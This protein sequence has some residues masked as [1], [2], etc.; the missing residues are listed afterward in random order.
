M[1]DQHNGISIRTMNLDDYKTVGPLLHGDFVND[2]PI[3]KSLKINV[4]PETIAIIDALHL[5]MIEEGTSLVAVEENHPERILGFVLAGAKTRKD[6]QEPNEFPRKLQPEVALISQLLNDLEAKANI[7][8]SYKVDRILYSSVTFVK[9]KMR[10]RGLGTRLSQALM[11]VGRTKGFPLMM[12][13]C[14]SFYS[15]RQKEALGMKC[16]LWQNYADYK[17]EQGCVIF[18]PSAPHVQSRV[19]VIE[20]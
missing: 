18:T 19:L 10:G 6:M 9:P 2:E 14:T 13:T 20:L 7:F 5:S 16:I 11:K 15:A 17:D 3:L 12:A 8:E 4:R 1:E